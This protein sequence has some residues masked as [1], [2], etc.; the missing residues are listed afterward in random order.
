MGRYV[1][2]RLLQGVLTLFLVMALLHLLTT[3]AIQ[4][5]GNPALAF[6]GDRVPTAA[7]VQAVSERYGLGD[8]CYNQVGNPCVGPFLDRLGAYATGDFGT[9]LR[10]R[11]VTEIVATAAPNTLRLF[12]VVSLTWLVIGMTLGSLAARFR[13]RPADHGIRAGS[14]LIDAFPVFVMLLVYKFVVTVPMSRWAQETF[15]RDSLPA[16]LFRPS[17]SA[18]HPWATIVVP[19]VLLGLAGSAAFIRLVRAAQLENYNA[20]HVR[21]ARSKGLGER[22]VTLFHIVR[23]SS[24]PV[25][26][27]IGFV[28]TEALAG[29][30]VTEGLMNVYGMGGVLW[31]A[32]RDSDVSVVVGIVTLLAVVTVAV[33]IVVDLLYA[34]LDPR[35]RFD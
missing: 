32:V 12:A 22:H 11:E 14:I 17:F 9:D 27:A 21:T 10:G 3:L 25:V 24:I 4:L 34:A 28:F 16:L 18:D 5:N 2:R 29:A 26:T 15:G 1:A 35:I 19:A 20:D 33:M 7:Q 13:G 8:P 30:V 23:N 31:G 6:F